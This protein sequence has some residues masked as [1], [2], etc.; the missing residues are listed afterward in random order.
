MKKVQIFI[1]LTLF[2]KFFYIQLRIINKIKSIIKS[3]FEYIHTNEA[4]NGY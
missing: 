3:T 1:N 4:N 2:H